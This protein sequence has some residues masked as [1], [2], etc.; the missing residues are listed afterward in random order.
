MN[1]TAALS[2]SCISGPPSVLVTA[3]GTSSYPLQFAP[4]WIGDFAAGLELTI[5]N[6]NEKHLYTVKVC[7]GEKLVVG[8]WLF[9]GGSCLVLPRHLAR[10]RTVLPAAR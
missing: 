1:V 9:S 2:G 4:S 10:L 3:N 5:T 8:S 7:V 6:T